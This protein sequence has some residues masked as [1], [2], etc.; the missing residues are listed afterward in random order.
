MEPELE[1]NSRALMAADWS[2]PLPL[3][4]ASACNF[5]AAS[6]ERSTAGI[7][8][9]DALCSDSVDTRCWMNQFR[10]ACQ[11]GMLKHWPTVIDIK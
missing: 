6:E 3:R 4:A 2:S 5:R 10:S 7:A 11:N 9:A 1:L 8:G